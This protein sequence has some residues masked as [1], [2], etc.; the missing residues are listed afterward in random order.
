VSA[1]ATI[2]VADSPTLVS[3]TVFIQN[4]LDGQDEQLSVNTAG[5]MLVSSYANGVL[6][7][8]GVAYLSDYLAVLQ[9]VSHSD[10]SSSPQSGNRRIAVV[11][12]DGAASSRAAASVIAVV[13]GAR[14]NVKTHAGLAPH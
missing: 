4:P 12:N 2:T 10:N 5:T 8:S 11:V 6:T 7:V 9:T 13:Q 1:D 3:M 14:A